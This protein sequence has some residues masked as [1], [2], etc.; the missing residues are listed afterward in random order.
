ML[1]SSL[2]ASII[3]VV[4]FFAAR[5]AL[6]SSVQTSDAITAAIVGAASG[7]GYFLLFRNKASKSCQ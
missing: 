7:F 4:V 3:T 5:F 6:G 2:L 1:V